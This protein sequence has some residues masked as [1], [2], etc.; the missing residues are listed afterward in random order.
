MTLD[1]TALH[2]WTFFVTK[3]SH[4]VTILVTHSSSYISTHAEIIVFFS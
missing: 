2:I 3:K 1:Y 4:Q